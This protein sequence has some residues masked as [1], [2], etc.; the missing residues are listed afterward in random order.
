MSLSP[1]DEHRRARLR[2]MK[3]VALGLLVLAA[4]IYLVTLNLDHAGG[5]GYVNTMAEAAMVGAL[6]DWFAVTALFRHPLGIPIP[7]TAIIPSK[8]DELAGSLQSFFA[9]NFLTEDVVRERI[10]EARLGRRL[11]GWL[12]Q[13]DHAR[14]VVDEGVRIAHALLRRV[15]DDDVR[16]VARDVL[17]PRLDREPLASVSGALLEG[18]VADRAHKGFVDLLLRETHTWLTKHPTQFTAML[19]DRAPRWAPGFLN[20]RVVSALY[21]QALDWVDRVRRD[22]EHPTRRSFDD[23]LLRIAADLQNDPSVQGRFETLKTRLLT[24]PQL[25]DALVSLWDSVRASLESALDDAGSGLR[26]RA[27]AGVE[28]VGE[29]L[30][31]DVALAARID[32]TVSDAAAYLVTSYGHELSSVI[33]HTI[34]RWD[35]R[36]ASRRIELY[37]GRDLQFIRINGTVVG[38]LAG[39]AIHAVSQLF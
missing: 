19:H 30:R 38:A 37:V 13:P 7:H 26:T 21:W 25:E 6:A 12:R 31:T 17:L 2:R 1:A 3:A 22:P 20:Q 10:G 16:F 39:L 32:T 11:G 28:G 36:D 4:A 14:R 33:G 5:W 27:I 24:H 35:G 15:S 9:D 8:K 18:I 34:Q 23:L 29:S